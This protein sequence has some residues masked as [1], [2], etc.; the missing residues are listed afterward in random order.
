[1]Y[2]KNHG[3]VQRILTRGACITGSTTLPGVA[4][5]CERCTKNVS[6]WKTF[7]GT[8]LPSNLRPTNR[9]C[10]H[11]LMRGYFRSCDKVGGHAN[12]SA[13]TKHPML[14]CKPHGC[15]FYRTAVMATQKF[16][17][18]GIWIFYLFVPVTLALTRWPSY[19]NLTRIPWRYTGCANMSFLRQS[20]LKL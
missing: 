14:H 7:Y 3:Q 10:V 16:Y 13:I 6:Q 15:T 9:E 2:W 1:M 8:R 20:F 17:I 11:L 19:T 12:R 5:K 18:A 4:R